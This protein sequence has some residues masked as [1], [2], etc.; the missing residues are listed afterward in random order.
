MTNNLDGILSGG[1]FTVLFDDT[2]TPRITELTG[3]VFASVPRPTPVLFSGFKSPIGGADATGGNFA[4]PLRTF[5]FKSTIPVKFDLTQGGVPASS[6]IHTLQAIKYSD[7]TT[8]GLPVDATPQDAA[9]AWNAFRFTGGGVALQSGYKSHWDECRHLADR[10]YAV[11]WQSASSLD[12]I[13]IVSGQLMRVRTKTLPGFSQCSRS[14]PEG[15]KPRRT[16]GA[17]CSIARELQTAFI[18][19][20]N[21]MVAT[22]AALTDPILPLRERTQTVAAQSTLRGRSNSSTILQASTG[23]AVAISVVSCS[24]SA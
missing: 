7:A 21:R 2:S 15:C 1:R 23:A 3:T 9:T 13:E 20:M 18:L 4:N 17:R 5:K 8:A 14:G 6:G 19:W 24:I 16:C 12:L 10:R 22:P 11:R